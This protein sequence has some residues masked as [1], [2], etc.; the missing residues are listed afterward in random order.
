[1]LP[2]VLNVSQNY[3]IRGGSD[4]YFFSLGELLEK[5]GHQVIPFAARQPENCETPWAHYFPEPINF[6]SPSARDLLRFV[7]SKP[8]AD[9][10]SRL[11]GEHR[12]AIAHLHIYYGQLTTSIL[13]PLKEAGIPIVQTLH[14]YRL[15][16]PVSTLM[17]ADG[18]LCQS[19]NG[20]DFWQAVAKRC[21]RGSLSRS[22][23][24]AAELYYSHALGGVIDKV[25][26][27][28]TV[29]HFQRRKLAE[30][31][32][33]AHKMV[34]VHNF[35]DVSNIPVNPGKGDYFLYF[36]RLER[37]KGIFTLIE[38]AAPLTEVPLLIVGDGEAR[39]E[40]EATVAR[41]GLSHIRVLGPKRGRELQQL[42]ADSLCC[43]LPSEWYENCPMAVLEAYAHSRPQIGADIGGIPELI[44]DGTDG[45]LFAPGDSEHLRECL[46]AMARDRRRAME[47]GLAGRQKIERYFSQNHHYEQI[48]GVYND[49]MGAKVPVPR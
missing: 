24:S 8:A 45:L 41:R 14:E 33:P 35:V 26:R 40:V 9:A 21:N 23:L 20:K 5:W 42:I 48:V 39:E 1:M 6:T 27:F 7:H 44:E 22:L 32:I 12:P 17:S 31:G 10:L 3:F 19:C 37:L 30:L 46:L 15:V 16:C 49:L 28:I 2:T 18:Q 29:S 34:T 47:M 38:A 13:R 25:D 4:R 43:V 11:L 36:G